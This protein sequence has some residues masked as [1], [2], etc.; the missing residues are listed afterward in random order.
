MALF[1]KEISILYALRNRLFYLYVI[2]IFGHRLMYVHKWRM[3]KPFSSKQSSLYII[4]FNNWNWHSQQ[5]AMD[6]RDIISCLIEKYLPNYCNRDIKFIKDNINKIFRLR[7][8]SKYSCLCK[9]FDKLWNYQ[10]KEYSKFCKPR[11][12][13]IEYHVVFYHIL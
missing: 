4:I 7:K 5:L 6:L 9:S 1:E 13:K 2:Y 8:L 3:V 12:D 10:N 11:N